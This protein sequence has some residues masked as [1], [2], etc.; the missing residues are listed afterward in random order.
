MLN[1]LCYAQLLQL[2]LTLCDAMDCSLPDSSVH[3]ILQWAAMPFS[4]GFPNPGTEPATLTLPAPA[5]RFF[6]F[7]ATGKPSEHMLD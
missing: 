3:G 7:S 5:T 6:T 4:R 1:M 2:C